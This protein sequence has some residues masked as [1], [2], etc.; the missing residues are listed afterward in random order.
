M[1]TK[2]KFILILIIIA[3][4]DTV[5]PIPFMAIMLIYVVLEKPVWFKQYVDEIYNS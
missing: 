2:N 5:I 4:L 1:T 3:V